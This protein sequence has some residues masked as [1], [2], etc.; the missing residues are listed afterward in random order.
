MKRTTGQS[1][2]ANLTGYERLY[3]LLL[4]RPYA[5]ITNDYEYTKRYINLNQ[6]KKAIHAGVYDT[7]DDS[8][9]KLVADVIKTVE[10]NFTA[11]IDKYKV[12]LYV[13][14][15]DTI[16]GVDRV[17]GMLENPG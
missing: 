13:G 16:V 3:N 1:L 7:S 8:Y 9:D 5:N 15:L 17:N 4:S 12:M 10:P 14:N 11:L 6:T 2:A